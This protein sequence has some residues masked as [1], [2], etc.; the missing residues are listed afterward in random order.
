MTQYTLSRLAPEYRR[1]WKEMQV[2]KT[3]AAEMQAKKIIAHKKR[4][5]AIEG[6]TGVPW[7]VV[8]CLHMRESNGNFNTYLGNGQPLNRVTTIVPKGRGPFESFEEGAEDALVT[9]E[10]LDQIKAWGPEHVAYAMEKFNGFG[11]RHP[12]RNIPSPYLWG[13]TSVQRRGKFIRDGVYD[14][15]VMDPQLGGMAVL[16]Q[17][18]ELDKEAKFRAPEPKP[19]PA[20]PATIEPTPSPRADDTEAEVKPLSKS[21]TMWGGVIQFLT[22]IGAWFGAMFE[23][24]ATPWGFALTVLVI[25]ALGIGTYLVIQGRI[26]VQAIIKHLSAEEE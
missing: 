22:G 21:K 3:Q 6:V 11:Y 17:I 1:L 4:Y 23:H 12:N 18:M 25:V 24:L 19:V 15:N 2:V 10:H 14:P 8:G 7:F 9:V 13:G 26:D 5:K 16:R 20:P